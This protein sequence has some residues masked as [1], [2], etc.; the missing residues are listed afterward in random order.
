MLQNAVEAAVPR[1]G[2][3]KRSND[4]EVDIGY[5]YVYLAST[6][7]QVG[8]LRR[9]ACTCSQRW[10]KRVWVVWVQA[11]KLAWRHQSSMY[12]LITWY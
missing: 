9:N 1:G 2:R 11:G 6:A 8:V 10:T 5:T 3:V 7:Q 4:L 12:D